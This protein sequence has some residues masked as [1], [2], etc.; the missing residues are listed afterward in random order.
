MYYAEEIP[1]K[2][3]FVL[4]SIDF[5][6]NHQNPTK[7]NTKLKKLDSLDEVRTTLYLPN[8]LHAIDMRTNE[9]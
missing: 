7:K 2:Y 4:N 9:E 1:F 3:V 5:V 8:R 6:E